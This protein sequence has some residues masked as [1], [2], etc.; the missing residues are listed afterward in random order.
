MDQQGKGSYFFF[1][2]HKLQNKTFDAGS[3]DHDASLK[4]WSVSV[5]YIFKYL[6]FIRSREKGVCNFIVI[7]NVFCCLTDT[8]MDRKD[9]LFV[10][11]EVGLYTFLKSLTHCT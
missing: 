9:K 1:K 10:V 4:S 11:N 3:E 2:R 5:V 7:K 6:F 8:K